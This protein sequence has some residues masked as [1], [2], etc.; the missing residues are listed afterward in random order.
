MTIENANTAQMLEIV[1][2]LVQKGL[3]FK[4]TPGRTDD[5]WEITLT[6]GY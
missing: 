3:T 2:G 4:V 5:E 1:A 6:G